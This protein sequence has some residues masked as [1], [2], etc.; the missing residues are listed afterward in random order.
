MLSEEQCFQ[1]QRRQ[2]FSVSSFSSP[3]SIFQTAGPATVTE[4]ARRPSVAPA[5]L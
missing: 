5:C 4:D 2:V 3:G 1:W